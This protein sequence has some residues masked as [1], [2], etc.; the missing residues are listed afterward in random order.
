MK[1]IVLFLFLITVN[2]Y[3]SIKI[4]GGEISVN[5]PLSG[6]INIIVLNSLDEEDMEQCTA[7]K[8][9]ETQIITAAHCLYDRKVEALGWSNNVE[10]SED[11][12]NDFTGLYVKRVDMHP[13]YEAQR[14][15]GSHE[16]LSGQDV[17]IVTFDKEKGNYWHEFDKLRVHELSFDFVEVG[18]SLKM[19]GYGCQDFIGTDSS[20]MLKKESEITSVDR[21][22]LSDLGGNFPYILKDYS[23]DIY[24]AKFVSPGIK[25]GQSNAS[26]CSGDSGGPVLN[27]N[28][29]VVGI[30]ASVIFNDLKENGDMASG[31]SYLNLHN[32]ISTIKDWILERLEL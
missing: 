3:A 27:S 17:A 29:E 4:I 15:L 8:V 11:A 7:T 22:W 18:A 30:N 6:I 16:K 2:S 19:F 20:V 12:T 24:S 31:V 32:R 23:T 26:M 5:D 21:D 9:S 10:Y 14:K 13:S 28:L 25:S 1:S